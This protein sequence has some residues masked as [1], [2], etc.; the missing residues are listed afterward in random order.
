S[1]TKLCD[2]TTCFARSGWPASYPVSSTATLTPL[3]SYPCFQAVGAPICFV[4]RSRVACVRPSSQI[5]V[6]WL[7][8][9]VVGPLMP[10]QKVFASAFRTETALLPTLG[11]VRRSVA[12][13]LRNVAEPEISS[14][15]WSLLASSYPCA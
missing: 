2:A 9:N 13:V 4:E 7:L 3:P 6:T 15:N 10:S 11:S 12:P 1:G 5:L 8:L 14:G